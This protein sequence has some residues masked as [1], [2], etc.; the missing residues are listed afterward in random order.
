MLLPATRG[1][2][3]VQTLVVPADADSVRLRLELESSDFR[4]YRATVHDEAD[5][6]VWRSGPIPATRRG[7][8]ASTSVTISAS[9]LRPGSFALELTGVSSVGGG[10]V[11]ANYAFTVARK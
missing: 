6:V 8:N 10:E 4:S 2:S 3:D 11:V 7:G 1:A 9:L 5:R